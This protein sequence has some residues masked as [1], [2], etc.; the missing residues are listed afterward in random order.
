MCGGNCVGIN[1]KSVMVRFLKYI[2]I[3][4]FKNGLKF[5]N[6]WWVYYDFIYNNLIFK[7]GLLY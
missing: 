3:I 2:L 5:K 6:I 1:D 4:Y 7:R